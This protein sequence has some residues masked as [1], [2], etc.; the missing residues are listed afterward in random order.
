MKCG[1]GRF[2]SQSR[3]RNRIRGESGGLGWELQQSL[4]CETDVTSRRKS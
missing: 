1:A 4:M 3:G 2:Y